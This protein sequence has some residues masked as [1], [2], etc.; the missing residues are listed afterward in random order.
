MATKK[1]NADL[2]TTIVSIRISNT[3]KAKLNELA[4]SMRILNQKDS[5][6]GIPKADMTALI[7]IAINHTWGID[8]DE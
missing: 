5:N 4:D 2:E 3:A 1:R 8:C 6:E 7:K